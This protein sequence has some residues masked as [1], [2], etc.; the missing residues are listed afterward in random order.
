MSTPTRAIEP[1]SIDRKRSTN[2]TLRQIRLPVVDDHAAVRLGLVQLLAGQRD[3]TVESVCVNAEAAIAQAEHEAIGVAVVDYHLGGRNGLWACRR[4]KRMAE[5]PRVIIFSAFANDH[6][7]ECPPP[8]GKGPTWK[9]DLRPGWDDRG[10]ESQINPP[11]ERSGKSQALRLAAC[12][13][14]QFA[15]Y[16]RARTRPHLTPPAAAFPDRL[17]VPR[18]GWPNQ[19]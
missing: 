15:R 1:S 10:E 3:F 5:Q 4:L 6:L 11:G 16:L 19:P 17:A 7:P 18:F 8:R 13:H 12:H 14:L 9:A 2:P